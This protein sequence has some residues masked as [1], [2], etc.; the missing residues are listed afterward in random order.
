MSEWPPATAGV[1]A[2]SIEAYIAEV[3]PAAAGSTEVL[4]VSGRHAVVRRRVDPAS[5]RPGA[6]VSGP[7]QFG[8][9]D[10]ALWFACFGAI[11]LEAMA[12]TSEMS[13]RYL[14][15]C[16]GD[17]LFAEAV[18]DSVGRRTIVGSV[19]VWTDD[20]DRPTSVAQGS[21]VRPSPD[22]ER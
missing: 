7:T 2:E 18:L 17:E 12:V 6:M 21:Y 1:T 14:R 11:G 3:W 15:P 10:V 8:M 16:V 20:R 9:A 13:I 4:E 22:G 19:R 5:L